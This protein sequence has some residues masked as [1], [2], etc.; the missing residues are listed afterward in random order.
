MAELV[1]YEDAWSH[2]LICGNQEFGPDHI[3]IAG[4]TGAGKS[5]IMNNLIY[6]VLC[7]SSGEHSM[8]LIDPK[9]L[10][11]DPYHGVPHE[12][13]FAET[14]EQIVETL[15]K[16]FLLVQKR[17]DSLRGTGK[18]LYEGTRIHIFIDELMVIMTGANDGRARKYLQQILT[19][20]RAANVQVIMATQCPKA[21]IIP[22]EIK[23]NCGVIIGLQTRNNQ[24]SRNILGV[25]GCERLPRH[26]K[27]LVQD[28][29]NQ[30][31]HLVDLKMVDPT[32]IDELIEF[33]LEGN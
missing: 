14:Y 18:K 11:F 22:T 10:E 9:V 2:E 20:A 25:N 31:P 32:H 16:C 5:T 19:L 7:Q 13:W 8:V 3:L 27:A 26:G 29:D 21:N 17:F 24:D 4:R 1:V 30:E 12:V 28:P 33:R 15:R 6:S 23:A